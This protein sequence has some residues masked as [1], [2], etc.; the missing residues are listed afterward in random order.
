MLLALK[1]SGVNLGPKE[2]S[3]LDS[4]INN[5]KTLNKP[6]LRKVCRTLGTFD[7][8]GGVAGC[9]EAIETI[10]TNPEKISKLQEIKPTS[11]ALGKVKNAAR[12]FLSFMGLGKG[13]GVEVFRGERAGASG[14][15]AKY[16]PGTSQVEF[17]PYSDKLKGRFF[18]TSKL[19]C[20][21][22]ASS[23]KSSF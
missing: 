23:K 18:T 15:M 4:L 1:S 20:H 2:S 9:A 14:K 19:F 13:E 7:V 17:V 6:D 8:G 11:A 10:K 16:I 22:F 3:Q 21:S 5:I 12:S